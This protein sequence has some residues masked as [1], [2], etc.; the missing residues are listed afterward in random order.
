[1]IHHDAPPSLAPLSLVSSGIV[2]VVLLV[3][4][5]AGPAATAEPPPESPPNGSSSAGSTEDEAPPV[6]SDDAELPPDPCPLPKPGD[7]GTWLETTRFGVHKTVCRAAFW[8]DNL[9]GGDRVYEEYDATFGSIQPSLTLDERDG[10]EPNLRLRAKFNL[11]KMDDRLSAVLGRTS[12]E[13]FVEEGAIAPDDGLPE[14]FR[15]T[16]QEWLLGLG[17]TPLRSTRRRFDAT[18]GLKFRSPIELFV[19]GRYRRQW[20][21]GDRHLLRY[22][23]TAF[24]STDEGLGVSG[25]LDAERLLNDSYLLRWRNTATLAERLEGVEWRSELVLF[26]SFRNRQAL[27]YELRAE[28][29][30]EADVT[31]DLYGGRVLYRRPIAR[32]W[33]FLE[34]RP[35]LEWRRREPED[36]RQGYLSF[37]VGFELYFGDRPGDRP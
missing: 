27:A 35:G 1:M 22:R 15:D 7:E 29:E 16:D 2:F 6:E 17:Y 4:L 12:E 13:A 25:R 18:A 8:F 23:Q 33:L 19:Q 5:A 14:S 3:A 34:L 10:L 37:G 30:S 26:H 11:P 9:F 20:F 21:F 36:D 28:G 32:D 24:W 31:V